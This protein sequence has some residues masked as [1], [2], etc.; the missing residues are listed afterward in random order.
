MFCMKMYVPEGEHGKLG[1]FGT[2]GSIALE[3]EDSDFDGG[4]YPEG[5]CSLLLLGEGG[6]VVC[7]VVWI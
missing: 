5:V 1:R 4:K 2:Y 7:V 3:G 6:K